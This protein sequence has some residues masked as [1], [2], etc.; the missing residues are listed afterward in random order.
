[1]TAQKG[2][3]VLVRVRKENTAQSYE[4]LAGLRKRDIRFTTAG[5][6]STTANSKSGWREMMAGAGEKSVEISGEGVFVDS[7]ADAR[8]STAFWGRETP[9][10]EFVV[11]DFA[12]LRGPF[13]ISELRYGGIQDGEA[14]FAVKLKS[15]GVISFEALGGVD[16]FI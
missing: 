7:L 6:V 4:T 11:P 10:F 13:L 14:D 15:A 16:G 5:V 12:I 2:R 3:D 9:D 8:L 1:M